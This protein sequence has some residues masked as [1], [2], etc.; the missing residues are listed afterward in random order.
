MDRR[1]AIGAMLL[2]TL[3]LPSPRLLRVRGYCSPQGT[4]PDSPVGDKIIKSVLERALPAMD[5]Q[6]LE[7]SVLSIEYPPGSSSAPHRHP[8]AVV[9]YVLEGWL[10]IQVEGEPLKTYAAGEAFYE[11]PGSKHLVGQNTSPNQIARLLA[12]HVGK[13]GTPLTIPLEEK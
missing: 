3:R 8:G 2:G 6:N 9:G 13:I 4:Q 10:Q 1:K 7:V 5:G 11:P 12:F